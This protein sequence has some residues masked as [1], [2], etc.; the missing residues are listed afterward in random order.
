MIRRHILSKK[1]KENKHSVPDSEKALD[2]IEK[3]YLLGWKWQKNKT[4][5]TMLCH[6]ENF[7]LSE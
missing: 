5:K 7:P 2:H 4:N 3:H 1:K 6:R